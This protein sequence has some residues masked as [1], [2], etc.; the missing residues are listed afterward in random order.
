MH[1]PN[2]ISTKY[3]ISAQRNNDKV[4]L[5]HMMMMMMIVMSEYN[6]KRSCNV[7]FIQ[8][9]LEYIVFLKIIE[10]FLQSEN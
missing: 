3:L 2:A 8:C 5:L 6:K 10:I 7:Y 4:N 9:S 1:L